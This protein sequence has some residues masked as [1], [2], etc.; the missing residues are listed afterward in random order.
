MVLPDPSANGDPISLA[1]VQ[2]RDKRVTRARATIPVYAWVPYTS[3][4]HVQVEAAAGEWTS[5]A[6]H[7]RWR[8]SAGWYYVWVWAPAVSRRKRPA[9]DGLPATMRPELLAHGPSR[10]HLS[11]DPASHDRDISVCHPTLSVSVALVTPL[12]SRNG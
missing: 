4:R 7:I 12:L 5:A 1:P 9:I 3:G 10:N 8:D 11:D 6:V 2:L